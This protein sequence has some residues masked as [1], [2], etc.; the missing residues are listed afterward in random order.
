LNLL[1]LWFSEFSVAPDIYT[2]TFSRQGQGITDGKIWESR[3]NDSWLVSKAAIIG[4]ANY[5]LNYKGNLPIEASL[6]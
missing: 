3:L 4:Q 1:V 6:C 5:N 2:R